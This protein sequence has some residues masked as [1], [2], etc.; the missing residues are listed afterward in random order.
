MISTHFTTQSLTERIHIQLTKEVRL[1]TALAN[2]TGGRIF[3][4]LGSIS[5]QEENFSLPA[6]IILPNDEEEK[7]TPA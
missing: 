6:C 7:T 3:R 4:G 5:V 1:L 2:W